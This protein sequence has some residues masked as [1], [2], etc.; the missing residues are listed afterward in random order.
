MTSLT[1]HL[2]PGER[3]PALFVGHGNPMHA[4][5]DSDFSRGWAAAAEALPKP[6]AI[7]CVSA[8]W[9]TRGATLV[10]VSDKPETIH[11]FGGFPRKLF[12]QQ[13]PAP[14][15]PEM[16]ERTAELLAKH[17][18]RT[19]EEWGLD[20]GAWAV[21]IRMY[22]EAD[23]PVYQLSLDLSR[24]VRE[25]FELAKDLK[26]LREMGVLIVASGNMVHNL[27]A[28]QPDADPY[29]W[30]VEFDRLMTDAIAGRRFGEIAE[31]ERLGRLMQLAHPTI[32]HFLPLLYLLGVAHEAD[33]VSFFNEG[34]DLASVSMRCCLFA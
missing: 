5:I 33:E 2:R 13:Y 18:A 10:Q 28:M 25:H 8:H 6:T 14:G 27:P 30:A 34:I 11:D 23:V 20:H 31:A 21:L 9:M 12:E 29:D 24:P 3:M 15:S 17:H 16:A 26:S 4:I 32:E 19:S 7:L 1:N 22:P